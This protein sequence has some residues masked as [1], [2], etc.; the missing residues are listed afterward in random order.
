[1]YLCDF[2][3]REYGYDAAVLLQNFAYWVY[4]NKVTDKNF[5][6]GRYWTYSTL[7]HLS[8]KYCISSLS[9]AWRSITKLVKKNILIKSRNNKVK[10]DRTC[11]YAFQDEDLFNKI[12][13]DLISKDKALADLASKDKTLFDNDHKEEPK[14]KPESNQI[15]NSISH[16]ENSIFHYETPIPNLLIHSINTQEVV[17][18]ETKTDSKPIDST[19]NNQATNIDFLISEM[20]IY[21]LS[22]SQISQ[23][24]NKYD[25][26]YIQ[27]KIEQFHYVLKTDPKKIKNKAR[28]LYM[29]IIDNWIDDLFQSSKY[30][31]I[32]RTEELTEQKKKE[33]QEKLEFEKQKAIELMAQEK[34]K[35]LS[36]TEKA[37]IDREIEIELSQMNI[38]I[39]ELLQFQKEIKR[40]E[41][42]LKMIGV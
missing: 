32:K 15:E 10:Y 30:S 39:P 25:F 8:D 7:E 12:I 14:M 11:W 40:V 3:N 20:H 36:D 34:Y 2:L 33:N 38:K 28:Y 41:R 5:H 22:Q 16:N 42:V 35:T 21:K 23:I 19:K 17:R 9:K 13:K 24:I 31:R 27:D 4:R 26:S 18:A 1:M 6:D 29:T 37:A